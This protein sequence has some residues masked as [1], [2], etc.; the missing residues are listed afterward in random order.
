LDPW[1]FILEKAV[2]Y[3]KH[4]TT[5]RKQHLQPELHQIIEEYSSSQEEGLALI[6]LNSHHMTVVATAQRTATRLLA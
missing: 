5:A 3:H 4:E 2:R 6:G 1:Y